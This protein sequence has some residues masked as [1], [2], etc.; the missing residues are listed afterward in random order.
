V[1]LSSICAGV[2]KV[3]SEHDDVA[4]LATGTGQRESYWPILKIGSPS[5]R[6]Y[7][8]SLL[9]TD[10]GLFAPGAEYPGFPPLWASDQAAECLALIQSQEV[11]PTLTE[12]P[13]EQM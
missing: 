8:G 10:I 11:S 9:V 12:L 2:W 13:Q 7:L 5:G 1:Q 6:S 3:R 4:E